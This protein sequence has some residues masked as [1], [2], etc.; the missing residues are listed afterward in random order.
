[1]S[2]NAAA[3]E[4]STQI[5]EDRVPMLK[6]VMAGHILDATARCGCFHVEARTG[7][8]AVHLKRVEQGTAGALL[9]VCR[10]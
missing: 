3:E 5:V 9:V 7:N 10:A 6:G 4:I 2:R 1:L 8:R